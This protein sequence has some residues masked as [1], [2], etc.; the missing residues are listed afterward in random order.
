MSSPNFA[1]WIESSIAVHFNALDVKFLLQGEAKNIEDPGTYLVIENLVLGNM[2]TFRL[3]AVVACRKTKDVY[4]MATKTGELA[5][6]MH[7]ISISKYGN[8]GDQVDCAQPVSDGVTIR[9][10]GHQEG[11]NL[12][13][14]TVSEEYEMEIM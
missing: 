4:E 12:L 2:A 5:S 6:Y 1:R 13:V 9:N 14:S 7:T 3:M 10:Y 11:S 8:G